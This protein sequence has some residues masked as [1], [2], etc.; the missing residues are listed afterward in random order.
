MVLSAGRLVWEK[1]HQDVLRAVAALRRGVVAAPRARVRV[2]IVGAG[3]EEER[4]RALRLRARH[5]RPRRVCAGDPIRRDARRYT[6]SAS[7][8]VLGILPQW[9]WEEQFGMVLAEAMAARFR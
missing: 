4:L 5:R 3:P 8:M 7:C 6:R 9:Y 2:L 1:G